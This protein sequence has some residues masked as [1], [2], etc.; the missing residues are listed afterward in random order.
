M[1]RR[2]G[3]IALLLLVAVVG[4]CAAEAP[5]HAA[6]QQAG[7]TAASKRLAAA[8]TKSYLSNE[9]LGA[10]MD[11]FMGR[12][13]R[14]GRKFAV[15]KS[16]GGVPFWGL[17]LSD[18][19]GADEAEPNFAYI[20]NMH[21]NEVSGR[22]LLPLLAEWLCANDGKD[23]RATRLLRDA[24]LFI[25]PTMNPDGFNRRQRENNKGFDLNRNFPDPIVD[26]GT[27]LRKARP[28]TQPE[29]AAVMEW[30]LG[31]NWAGSANLHEGAVVVNYPYDGYTAPGQWGTA[32]LTP[33]DA[34][35]KFLSRTYANLN[36]LMVK[37]KEFP[38]GIT[39]GAQWYDIY[40]GMQ[41]WKYTTAGAM[42]LT[43]EVSQDKW[44]AASTL[45]AIW[46]QNRDAMIA[47]ATAAAFGGARGR[48]T[49]EGSGAPLAA[50]LVA[51]PAT[52]NGYG[53]PV[54]FYA[55]KGAGFYARPLAPGKYTLVAS[56]PGY[57][58]AEAAITVPADGRGV[59]QDFVL[60][61]K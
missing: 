15:G 37:S 57:A 9:Q 18:K 12:C 44:P 28:Q 23:E 60:K 49:A 19:P 21:G 40:G 10:W 13:G 47:L 35:F 56:A 11:E 31:R 20:A 4:L 32:H 54:P 16:A 17:E 30:S 48:V 39:N 14:I 33:D 51:K 29:V 45:G 36:P 53:P 52:P 42:E 59:A 6:K 1:A 3:V 61:T 26:K 8:L 25:L 7:A 50:T 46:D 41:D 24:H 34:T 22:A 43:L 2:M 55:S 5:K 58:P 38:G 27:D